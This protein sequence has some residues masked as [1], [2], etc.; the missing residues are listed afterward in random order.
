VPR[1]LNSLDVFVY[2]VQTTKGMIDIPPTV[3]ECLA[4]GCALVTTEKGGI[5]EVIRHGE[6]GLLVPADEVS[7]PQAYATKIL[8]LIEDQELRSSLRENAR[9]SAEP[10]DVSRIAPQV[11]AVYEEVLNSRG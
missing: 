6:N 10:Y 1:F 5:P 4:A 8:E 11:L 9:R 3:L 2:A 7:E